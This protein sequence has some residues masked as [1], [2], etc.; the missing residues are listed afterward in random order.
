MSRLGS[1]SSVVLATII[2]LSIHPKNTERLTELSNQL[3]IIHERIGFWGRQLRPRMS[4]A[5]LKIVETRS[6]DDIDAALASTDDPYPLALMDVGR[7]P[8]ATL[9]ELDRLKQVAPN[10]FVL[11]LDAVGHDEIPPTART[12]GATHVISGPTIPP[13]VARLLTRWKRLAGERA[14][15]AGWRDL[16]AE[17][18]K[19]E[20]WNWISAMI[21]G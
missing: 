14:F 13:D 1:P 19:P 4:E 2:W 18:A 11:I 3:L 21:E 17:S 15:N 6:R 16:P 9:E 20:P 5:G 12:L 7:R 10:A 8:S